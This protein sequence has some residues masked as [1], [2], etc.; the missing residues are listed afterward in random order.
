[1]VNTNVLTY[2]P[3]YN[4]SDFQVQ[5]EFETCKT[6]LTNLM[7]E[8]GFTRVMQHIDSQYI[9]NCKY[10]DIDDYNAI[11]REKTLIKIIHM[12]VR[13]LARNNVKVATF[14]NL[15]IRP[16]DIVILSEIGREGYRYLGAVSDT[17]SYHY[18]TPK[19]NSYGGVA[20]MINK[21]T[22]S[23]IERIDLKLKQTCTCADCQFEN[24]WTEV[25]FGNTSLIVGGIYR[26]PKG[27]V[28]HFI[29]DLDT[30]LRKLPKDKLCTTA[31]DLN[32]NLI[33]YDNQHTSDYLTTL[34]GYNF[35]PKITLPTRITDLSTTL[36]DHIF[37]RMPRQL[38]NKYN[39]AGNLYCDISDHL[40]NFLIIES[41][42]IVSNNRPMTRIF[43]EK[44]ILKFKQKLRE[45]NWDNILNNRNPNEMYEK[46]IETI[47]CS[48]TSSFPLIR[49]SRRRAKDK[50]WLTTGLKI[51]IRHK[52]RLYKKYIQSPSSQN[53]QKYIIYKNKLITC[54]K[55]AAETYYK[56]KFDTQ[57]NSIMNMWKYLGK[58]I[59]PGQN[60]IN[61]LLINGN[62]VTDPQDLADSM[63]EYFCTIGE[64]LA[65][66]LDNTDDKKFKK[67]LSKQIN[68]TF[69]LDPT[70]ANEIWAEINKLDIRKS[71]GEDNISPKIVKMCGDI[72]ANPLQ[73]IF[74]KA[75]ADADYPN[76]LKIAKVLSLYKKGSNYMC[77]NYRPISLLPC[78]D[79]LF[80]KII[81]KR[82][83]RFI[84]KHSILYLQQ[85]GFRKKYSTILALI[86]LTDKIKK[87]LNNG[88]YAIGIYLDLRKAFD[89]VNHQI[90]LTK[91]EHYGFRGHVNKF[92][93]SYL[94]NRWQF[95]ELNSKRSKL[96]KITIG[97]PQGSVL[98]PLFFLIYI[99]DIYKCIEDADTTLFADDTSVLLSDKSLHTLKTKA[100]LCMT[101]LSTWL[102]ENRLSLSIE[103]T[104]FI[105]YHTKK[106][107][108][109]HHFNYIRLGNNITIKRVSS[110]KYLGLILDEHMSWELQIKSICEN[111]V[112]FM[113]IFYNTRSVI[114][115][116]SKKQLYYAFVYSRIVYGLE[117][118]GSSI[119][120][121]LS[122]VQ[123]MQNKLLKIL[124]NKDRQY[125]TTQLHQELGL[126]L[127]HDLH[128]FL[129]LKFIYTT[130]K[131][132]SIDNF[133]NY[134]VSRRM[135]HNHGT[136]TAGNIEVDRV[137][138]NYGRQRVHFL[139][140]TLWNE[141]D[142]SIKNASSLH[143]FKRALKELLILQYDN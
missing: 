50:I 7:Y 111:L 132:T 69:F 74:N 62:Y 78:F 33:K 4:L 34:L 92:I 63:N 134:F 89:T 45:V 133:K 115:F 106:R 77:E 98:G 128:K 2:M 46:L 94:T 95:T 140:A 21:D 73:I 30:T 142:E 59:S 22:C 11:V 35:I 84:N 53:K 65:S 97:V 131:G 32:I 61:K 55:N 83:M 36:I 18:D 31:G 66:S 10:Y 64:K 116:H 17:Y 100:E 113:G 88:E 37:L 43:S 85:F 76:K 93:T 126:L 41:D 107:K 72:L 51:S 80:E 40:P 60:I 15:F 38:S 86:D 71:A 48:F 44:N 87:C 49:Q 123:I 47:Q 102:T 75:M 141:L 79:K 14:L 122:K 23:G 139:C 130:I 67:Y 110:I 124:F 57:K 101:K 24:V 56:E 91:L 125:S 108:I 82:F 121:Q 54:I 114:P 68:E 6:R 117:V 27:N 129:L 96:H 9:F 105:I 127:V 119:K 104:N 81:Y 109:D 90:L 12:N 112:K 13:M 16:F 3:F 138:N 70:S 8:T 137:R 103:K 25:T 99:N 136:R 58:I 52:N 20:V 42:K 143:V 29:N 120:S 1:M 118:Y 28:S 26:H 5:M 39:L 135:T 19:A